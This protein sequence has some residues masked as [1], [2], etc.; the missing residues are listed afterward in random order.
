MD[1]WARWL[2][3]H[4]RTVLVLA[5]CATLVL[6]RDARQVRFE[7][8]LASV[9]PKG[10]PAV[11]FY[12]ETRKRFGSDDVAV[13]GVRAADVFT[14]ATLTKIARVTN[15][16]AKIDGVESALSL[17]NAS[18]VAADV[19]TPPPLLPRIPPTAADIAAL[20]E[21]LQKRPLYAKNMLAPDGKGAAITI[22]FRPLSDAEYASLD[23]EGQIAR[24]LAAAEGP[25]EF[26]YTGT[27][28]VK[29]E[30]AAMMRR[31]ILWL[32]PLALFLMTLAFWLSSRT[33][34][35][36]I[37]PAMTVGVALVWTLGILVVLGK[38]I[39]LGTFMVP[40]LLLVVGSA[41][42]IHVTAHYY[43]QAELS[44][45]PK[46]VVRRTIEAV[47]TPFLISALT[48]IV[49][50]GS[51]MVS[52]IPAIFD[53]GFLAVIG[54][55][56]LTVSALTIL[57]AMLV[58]LPVER[59]AQRA[60]RSSL[61]LDGLFV[62]LGQ[63]AST[64]RYAIL[65]TGAVVAG[66][67]FLGIP[68]IQADSDFMEYFTPDSQVRRDNEVINQEIVGSNVFYIVVEGSK[69]GT[70]ERWEVL[71]LV[72]ELQAFVET[73]PGVTSS[74]SLVDYLELFE[75]GLAS[76]ASRDLVVD[77]QGNLKAAEAPQSFWKVPQNLAPVLEMVKKSPSTF[78]SVVTPDFQSASI[79]VRTSLAG[80]RAIQATL[81][82]IR[83][84]VV[85]HFPADLDVEL[86][87]SLVLVNRTAESIVTGQVQSLAMALVAIFV[88]MAMMFLSMRIG[89]LAVIPNVLPVVFFFG[90]LGWLRIYLNLGTSLIAA[91]SLGLAVDSTIHYMARFN[92]E[93]QGETD[94][95]AAIQRAL[96]SV[97]TPI[98]YTTSA[99]L[100]GFLVFGLSSF[101]PI[102]DF[103]L[104]TAVTLA[105]SLVANLALLPALLAT[106]K[107][108]TLW[109][110]VGVRLGEEPTRTIPLFEGLRPSQAR[111]V[112][113][114]GE[115]RHFDP[116]EHV[117]RQG[118]EGKEMYV[119]LNGRA[120]VL[121]GTDG[122]G[123]KQRVAHLGRGDVCGEMGLVRQHVRGAD[124]V[125]A[126]DVEVLAVNERFLRRIQRRY[127][128]IAARVFLN[129]T[130]ILSDRLEQA[131]QRFV[132]AMGQA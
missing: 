57:P 108:I 99:L 113:L 100:L 98:L 13:I 49:G 109:D 12:E 43:E 103:G 132:A 24:I 14:P 52:R 40:P 127:P 56:A 84:Y 42:V 51:L 62:R 115:V 6:G 29:Y 63:W 110:L 122:E 25:E 22:F 67:G 114:M 17:T 83:G 23:I 34:R 3:A 45:D 37:L 41:Y 54:V 21:T 26:F 81:Q 32:A 112:V 60:K 50:F 47:W 130:R 65:A 77:E 89:F 118:E 46:E 111:V 91:T 4:P 101:V 19:I 97:G 8:S 70:M 94:Q 126:S 95:T 36:V 128:R 38:A 78:S 104:L 85:A 44:N 80:T 76:G 82:K 117:I 61:V 107:I 39:T 35:G 53:L 7:S 96:R 9:L 31:D 106:T 87:G 121:I 55:A 11:A 79:L 92:R 58:L 131:N 1:R 72:K 116:G 68:R 69:P 16:L 15:E 129:L 5:A 119:L 120:E 33:K 93:L 105:S 28:H 48:T 18:D 124:V 125:A 71:R 123:A 64:Q 59:V 102:R 75:S 20:R 73:L 2:V 10:D 86:T 74:L 66:I 27:A 30:A 88:V 90:V